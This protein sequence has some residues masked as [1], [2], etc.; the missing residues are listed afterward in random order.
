MKKI[1]HY[2]SRLRSEPRKTRFILSRMLRFL[3][4]LS[5]FLVIDR[6][7][8]RLRFFPTSLS[9][10]IWYE[11]RYRLE[12][13][14]LYQKLLKQG[15]TFVDVGA[16]IGCH[17]LAG[18]IA[19]GAEG[20]VHS[21]EASPSIFDFLK[22]NVSL[23]DLPNVRL[24]NSA[25]GEAEGW[26]SFDERFLDDISRPSTTTKGRAMA[27]A[28]LDDMIPHGPVRLLKIDV[29]GY[30][31]KVLQGGKS[32]LSR[33]TFLVFE[34]NP[35]RLMDYGDSFEK[36]MSL[37]NRSGFLVYRASGVGFVQIN[38]QYIPQEGEDILAVNPAFFCRS[39]EPDL[40]S[41]FDA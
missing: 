33:T 28:R 30:E 5:G 40:G 16:N 19:V 26:I 15:S 23:N 12:E 4:P 37:L 7:L 9:T 11:P 13:E 31:Y 21:F 22:R 8:Y 41:L 25:L 36:I 39:E 29:E 27:V 24:Y 2:I 18:A 38:N 32:L 34:A 35:N 3:Y 1:S 14:E 10:A 6:G 20:A 17:T